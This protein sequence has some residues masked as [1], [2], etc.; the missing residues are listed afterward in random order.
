MQEVKVW[1]SFGFLSSNVRLT[2][3][4]AKDV[5]YGS[6][7]HEGTLHYDGDLEDLLNKMSVVFGVNQGNSS[8][9]FFFTPEEAINHYVKGSGADGESYF[10]EIYNIYPASY[11]PVELP[12][13]VML[14][15][16]DR[17]LCCRLNL[18]PEEDGAYCR[19]KI[20]FVDRSCTDKAREGLFVV[21]SVKDK[22]SYGFVSGYMKQY[23]APSTEQVVSYIIE[24]SMYDNHVSFCKS[25]VGDFA[26]INGRYFVQE[27]G[28]MVHSSLLVH[29]DDKLVIT[30]KATTG[31]DLVCE[32]Y[33]NCTYKEFRDRF[34]R[35][36]FHVPQSMHSNRFIS[37]LFDEA[38]DCGF[39][40]LRS[41]YNVDFVD[42]VDEKLPEALNQFSKDEVKEI[43]D[44]VN[45]INKN[46]NSAIAGKIKSGKIPML[47]RRVNYE[48]Q[49]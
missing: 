15:K 34:V 20:Y 30:D 47:T 42:V 38:E 1:Y 28:E 46:A 6:A 32:V 31:A 8:G 43:V 13:T 26:I 25:N 3:G 5:A 49:Y 16:G 9:H 12:T 41:I 37:D 19:G 14:Y 36:G 18:H 44:I 4:E 21:T 40:S 29:L 22:G 33:Q 11:K 2:K 45:K 7:V 23:K 35:F 27:D 48:Y 39:V 17:G 24:N 10:A